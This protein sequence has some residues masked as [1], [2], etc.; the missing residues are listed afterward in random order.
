MAD[1]PKLLQNVLDKPDDDGP[2][3][4]EGIVTDQII[5]IPRKAGVESNDFGTHRVDRLGSAGERPD[6]RFHLITTE[7]ERDQERNGDA[8]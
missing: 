8:G 4:K 6:E 5:G 3:L 2:V 1:D 7:R